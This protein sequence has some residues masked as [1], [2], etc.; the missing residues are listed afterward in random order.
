MIRAEVAVVGAGP[1]GCA[2]AV[3]LRAAGVGVVLLGEE[4]RER[5]RMVESIP[6]EAG[7]L[8]RRMGAWER[9]ERDGH[10][11]S[12]GVASAWGAPGLARRDAFTDPLGGGWLVDRD[13][14][15]AGLVAAARSAG[16]VVLEGTRVAGARRDS[17]GWRL[18]VPGGEVRAGFAVDASGRAGV[19]ARRLAAPLR[20]D[21]QMCAYAHVPRM[22]GTPQHTVLESAEDGW[23]Y[24]AALGPARTVAAFFS[25]PDVIRRSSAAAPAGWHALLRRTRQV[26]GLLGRPGPPPAVR[27]VPAASYCLTRLYGAGWAA[28][29]DAA[30]A[31]D[32]L[33]SAGV[34]TALRS[35][36][37][38]AAGVRAALGGDPLPL[39]AHERRTRARYTSY[40]L[41]RR[42]Y[43]GV[44]T[45]WPDAPFWHRRSAA[46]RPVAG[47]PGR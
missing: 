32:P 36:F 45:R 20:A 27:T 14:L 19:L 34:V 47:A 28:A 5:P 38:V 24:A 2:A 12:P 46:S 13:V 15:D 26:F 9:F 8:L 22:P 39:A 31:L 10:P 18:V 3:A 43:Y 35:G 41:Q 44:E 29:G 16:A 4:R 42:G 40:L 6:A 11:P 37:A 23:W 1:A 25:D 30:T 17:D 33:S 21:R 7:P